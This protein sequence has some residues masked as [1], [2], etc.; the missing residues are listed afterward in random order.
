M[1]ERVAAMSTAGYLKSCN[2]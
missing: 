1:S 2:P